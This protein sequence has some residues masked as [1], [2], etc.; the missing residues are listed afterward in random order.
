MNATDPFA[1]TSPA[2]AIFVAENLGEIVNAIHGQAARAVAARRIEQIVKHGHTRESD[3][4][5]EPDRLLR[6]AEKRLHD[7]RDRL[8][9]PDGRATA[10]RKIEIA[11]AMLL[12][13]HD[14]LSAEVV[15]QPR[16]GQNGG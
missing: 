3:R 14:K 13:L 9:C 6:E 10:L 8:A 11:A 2:E 15:L 1:V 5:R 4:D 7:A 16:E 12:A